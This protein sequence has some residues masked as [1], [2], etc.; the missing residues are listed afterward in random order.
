M[1]SYNLRSVA[2]LFVMLFGALLLSAR[3]ARSLVDALSESSNSPNTVYGLGELAGRLIQAACPLVIG[4]A[5]VAIAY[6]HGFITRARA[7]GV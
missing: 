1:K 5:L 7:R 6:R 3:G 2:E 4:M